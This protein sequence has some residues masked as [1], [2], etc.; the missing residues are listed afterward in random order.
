MTGADFGHY[1]LTSCA[2]AALLV[3]CEGSQAPIGA[4]GATPH[5]HRDWAP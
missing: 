1:A 5:G 3:G 2:A 4:P